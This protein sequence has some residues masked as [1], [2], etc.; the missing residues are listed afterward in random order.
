MVAFLVQFTSLFALIL[1]V[2]GGAALSFIAAPVAF[3]HAE[4][5]MA[6]F[7]RSLVVAGCAT[8]GAWSAT[9][10]PMRPS[11]TCSRLA[12]L[13]EAEA[14]ARETASPT[15]PPPCVRYDDCASNTNR[16]PLSAPFSAPT[17]YRAA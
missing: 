16:T 9:P 3:Q 5:G 14:G 13:A 12:A 4:G 2:G 6:G 15:D 17:S 8:A 11:P 1:W 10:R 7:A